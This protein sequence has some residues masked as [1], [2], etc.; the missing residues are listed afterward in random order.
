MIHNSLMLDG[1][2]AP[3]E[4]PGLDAGANSLRHAHLEAGAAPPGGRAGP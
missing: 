2:T 3:G 4:P 1:G